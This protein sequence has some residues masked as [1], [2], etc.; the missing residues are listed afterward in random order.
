MNNSK[1]AKFKECE[2]S[3]FLVAV[4]NDDDLK[5]DSPSLRPLIRMLKR[6]FR[7]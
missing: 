2:F 1:D 6:N 3:I 5:S 7:K 4:L